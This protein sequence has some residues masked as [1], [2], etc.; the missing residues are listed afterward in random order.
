MK[1]N[2]CGKDYEDK[3]VHPYQYYNP[4][5]HKFTVTFNYGSVRDG[6]CWEFH[7]CEDCLIEEVQN[8]CI[9]PKISSYE[10]FDN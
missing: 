10:I 5:I 1:C 3:K 4:M 9:L 6:E 7:K 2:Q 8:F